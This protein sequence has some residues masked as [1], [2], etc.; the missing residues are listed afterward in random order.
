MNEP[1]ALLIT[2]DPAAAD[3]HWLIRYGAVSFIMAK[4]DGQIDLATYERGTAYPPPCFGLQDAADLAFALSAAINHFQSPRTSTPHPS[5]IRPHLTVV[6]D[7][8]GPDA[9]SDVL[10]DAHVFL[11]E[12]C[13]N[14]AA[15]RGSGTQVQW[16]NTEGQVELVAP[17]DLGAL[18]ECLTIRFAAAAIPELGS[19]GRTPQET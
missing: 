16:S 3:T 17:V 4:R 6:G 9:A 2:D 11:D 14:A 12:T 1:R 13:I 18:G 5:Q 19:Q 7:E 10:I 8:P 15:D